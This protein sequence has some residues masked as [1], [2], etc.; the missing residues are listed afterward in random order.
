MRHFYTDSRK[1]TSRTILSATEKYIR[2]LA[3]D[4]AN[5]QRGLDSLDDRSQQNHQEIITWQVKAEQQ[6]HGTLPFNYVRSNVTII[7]D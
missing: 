3:E 5:L 1:Q 2:N 6:K 4:V 7:A